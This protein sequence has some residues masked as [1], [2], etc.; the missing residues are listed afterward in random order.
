MNLLEYIKGS[1]KGKSAHRLEKEAMQDPFLSDALE[2]YDKVK[3]NHVRSL[4][5]LQKQITSK[6]RKKSDALRNWSIAATILLLIGVSGFFILQKGPDYSTEENWAQLEEELISKDQENYPGLSDSSLNQEQAMTNALADNAGKKESVQFIPPVIALDEVS[7]AEMKISESTELADAKVA[8]PQ[9]IQQEE[10]AIA[11]SDTRDIGFEPLT[12]KPDTSAT[13][14]IAMKENDDVLSE[15]VVVG[16]GRSAK[17]SMTGSVS[18]VKP[19]KFQDYV[20]RGMIRPQDEECK[21][22]KGKVELSFYVD[23]QGRPHDIKI[24]KSLCSSADEEAIRLLETGPDWPL[25]DKQMKET[26]KF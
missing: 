26:V 18:T 24:E 6:S 16:T 11:D 5:N 23:E 2:G 10:L 3:G 8:V 20:K 7:D 25:T 15:V 9:T 17:K 19:E 13:M 14:M 21:D 1:R 4:T 22:V 12:I